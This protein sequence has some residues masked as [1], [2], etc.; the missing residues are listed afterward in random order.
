[1]AGVYGLTALGLTVTAFVVRFLGGWASLVAF[2]SRHRGLSISVLVLQ[3]FIAAVQSASVLD[4]APGRAAVR[5]LVASAGYGLAITLL[6]TNLAHALFAPLVVSAGTY[7]LLATFVAATRRDL[8]DLGP[9]VFVAVAGIV[10]SFFVSVVWRGS[11]LS[12]TL[13]SGVTMVIALFTAFAS[14]YVRLK[15]VA[16]E[17]GKPAV[18]TAAGALTFLLGTVVYISMA[19]PTQYGYTRKNP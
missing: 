8:D 18:A 9:S 19:I 10:L 12:F 16:R 2:A 14:A 3:L 6:A 1:M 5:Y 4:L 11:V 15:I 13:M 7:V 17:P